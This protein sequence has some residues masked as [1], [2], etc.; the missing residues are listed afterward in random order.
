MARPRSPKKL[1][2]YVGIY[3]DQ[4]YQMF[5][6]VEKLIYSL[7]NGTVVS[8]TEMHRASEFIRR[9]TLLRGGLYFK[10]FEVD[11]WEIKV[12][13]KAKAELVRDYLF[14]SY[15]K[16]HNGFL[17]IC[18]H[19]YVTGGFGTFKSKRVQEL[20][21]MAH[22]LK[23]NFEII[24]I[25]GGKERDKYT[26]HSDRNKTFAR[27]RNTLDLNANVEAV[28]P[29]PSEPVSDEPNQGLSTRLRRPASDGSD[30]DDDYDDDG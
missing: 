19:N 6:W 30:Y 10:L 28:L 5:P 3:L 7:N 18:P 29:E 11:P 1:P 9:R 24:E 8:T 21:L 13:T 23:V 12:A 20:I 22:E 17:F 25:D 2:R 16:F 15:L 14:L 4:H 27:S 26:K